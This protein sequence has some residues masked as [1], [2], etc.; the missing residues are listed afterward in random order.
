MNDSIKQLKGV[1]NKIEKCLIK[2]NIHTIT[3]LLFHLPSRYQDRTNARSIKSL[4]VKDE[5]LVFGT[6]IDK[7]INSTSKGRVLKCI[8]EDDNLDILSLC[9]FNFGGNL[10]R[11]LIIGNKIK[12]FGEIRY[13]YNNDLL[14][15]VHPEFEIIN[16]NQEQPDKKCLTPIYPTTEGL[17]QATLR[18]LIQQVLLL[19]IK[20]LLP[21]AIIKDRFFL[22]LPQAL[23]IIHNPP[24]N[25]NID[26]LMN[27]IHP[28]QQRLA[29]EEIL[30]H[31]LSVCLLS[32]TNNDKAPQF[33][34]DSILSQTLLKNLE[35]NLTKAQ[36]RVYIEIKQDLSK[37]L[38]MQRL[39]QGDV[40]SGK[41]IVAVLS[42][43]Q[44]VE[45]DYQVAIM[46]PTEL[47][48]EQ[49]FKT[50]TKWFNLLE[51]KIE[52]A[53]LVGSLTKKYKTLA[54]EKIKNGD[55]KV[56]IGTHALFQD[57]VKFNKLGLVI[58]DEQHRFGVHQRLAL[59]DKSESSALHQLIMTATPI[60][61]TLAMTAYADL[62]VSIIDELPAG[63]TPIT[64]VVIP[65]IRRDDIIQRIQKICL[66]GRQAYWV[67]PLV[68]ESETLQCQAVI[69]VEI[70][71]NQVLKD[72]NVK[73]VHGRMKSK[74]K[75]AIM[76]DFNAGKIN[77]LVA[78]TVIEVGVDVANASLM[79]VENAERM[80][81]SQLHQLRG[82]VG[83]GTLDS[84]CILLYKAPLSSIAKSRL[85]I[86]RDTQDGFIIAK[87]DLELRGA[88]EILGTKQTG[89]LNFRVANLQI[90]E[91][92][93]DDI[94]SILNTILTQYPEII[95]ELQQRW[96]G[97]NFNNAC[98]F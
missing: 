30:T 1:G 11:D 83:R 69:D 58:I 80:G 47:L 18:K 25:E 48:A 3:D 72:L 61:R 31:N 21:T 51:N 95:S 97:N 44:A 54:L 59:C 92:L 67:C 37:T 74:E 49:H 82:R 2:L 34:N 62:K 76:L 56:I 33:I 19:P 32:K 39:L 84:Y 26:A 5:T 28:A 93:L 9:W 77:I 22:T 50:F 64:T 41:T 75:E 43:L 57:A 23:Q 71:L 89:I 15:I 85:G 36:Q 45:S 87:Y 10:Q 96:L 60:P 65:S 27:K 38:P 20:E 12:C 55:S 14:E 35:F 8:I 53:Y 42:A 88:G 79:I 86:L 6:I 98:V 70:E 13:G 81:L 90:H 52:I 40:G 46:A 78:T 73:M 68:E 7:K 4:T 17:Y 94:N 16:N 63:R 91:N 24:I 66:T 29:F